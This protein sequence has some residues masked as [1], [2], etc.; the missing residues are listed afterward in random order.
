[1][2]AATPL[3]AIIA[4]MIVRA[5]RKIVQHF[6]FHHATAPADAVPYLPQ[7]RIERSQFDRLKERGVIR[8]EGAG[9]Y[10][11]DTDAFVELERA[12]HRKALILVAVAAVVAAGL[13]TFAYRG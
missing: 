6:L 7:S 12:R 3:P 8:E 4:A 13:L 10:W 11:V 5:R 2:I 1:M 9:R